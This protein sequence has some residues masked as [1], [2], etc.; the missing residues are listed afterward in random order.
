[1]EGGRRTTALSQILKMDVA[2]TPQIYG[3]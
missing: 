3:R 1:M 2:P